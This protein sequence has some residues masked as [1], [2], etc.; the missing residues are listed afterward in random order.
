MKSFYEYLANVKK[1]YKY[2][3]KLAVPVS[4][5]TMDCIEKVLKRYDVIE[6]SKPKKG[7]LQSNEL[8]FPGMG[9]VETVA[10]TITT[11]RPLVVQS[12]TNDLKASLN[13][14]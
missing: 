14:S 1:E 5:D 8:D 9:P 3:I 10:L 6:I 12:L 13:V 4:D 11:E 7:I 2:K